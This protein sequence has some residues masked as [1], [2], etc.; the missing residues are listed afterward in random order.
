MKWPKDVPREVDWSEDAFFMFKKH[1]EE[2]TEESEDP[3][4]TKYDILKE[5]DKPL[6]LES[7]MDVAMHYGLG[8]EG[9][10]NL[11]A[12][13]KKFGSLNYTKLG[14]DHMVGVKRD[15]KRDDSAVPVRRYN[16]EDDEKYK[17][18]II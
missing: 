3:I 4:Y 1:G 14:Q 7:Y 13:Y 15:R 10:E 18:L 6:V 16:I 11:S 9:L 17:G 5:L 2:S 8:V 12:A